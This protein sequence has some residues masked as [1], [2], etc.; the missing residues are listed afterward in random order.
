MRPLKEWTNGTPENNYQDGTQLDA[1]DFES[2]NKELMG[3]LTAAGHVADP[4]K[5]DQLAKAIKKL[6]WGN[7]D[8]R[9]T[10]LS[11]WGIGDALK[12]ISSS[13]SVSVATGAWYRIAQSVVGIER[14]SGEFAIRWTAASCHGAVRL[15]AGCH[16]GADGSVSLRQQEYG[17]FNASGITAARIVYHTTYAGNQAF[18]EVMFA[19]TVAN[20]ALDVVGIDLLGWSLLPVGTAGE[21]PAGYTSV[22]RTFSNNPSSLTAYGITPATQA[23]MDAGDDD[24]VPV[25]PKKLRLGFAASFTVNGYIAV[26][27][28][29]GGW[30]LQ[31]GT[32][33]GQVVAVSSAIST[34]VTF[35]IAFPS[36]CLHVGTT[37]Q[38]SSIQAV[39]G[40]GTAEPTVTGFSLERRNLATSTSQTIAA[41]W[42]AFGK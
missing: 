1:A 12:R 2:W 14:N 40:I 13:G 27:I 8:A 34:A 9:P 4:S 28:W 10:T 38:L 31:W 37:P 18:L 19:T 33:V 7:D 39:T 42:W 16:Y 22:E 20:V 35:P 24:T 36:L 11:G 21:V 15:T 5:F 32:V 23:Q 29:L 25:T 41:K 3:V 30:V 26:P 17:R 6:I